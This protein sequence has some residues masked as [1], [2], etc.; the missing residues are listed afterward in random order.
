MQNRYEFH[1]VRFGQNSTE[2]RLAF[3]KISIWDIV[4]FVSECS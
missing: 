2:E 3:K 4:L 1:V